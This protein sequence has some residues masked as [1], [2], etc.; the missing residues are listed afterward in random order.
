MDLVM[1]KEWGNHIRVK[2][3]KFN[4]RFWKPIECIGGNVYF[5]SYAI[6]EDENG[7]TSLQNREQIRIKYEMGI[8]N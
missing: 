2:E 7:K 5:G 4:W 3:W 6:V 8:L 1:S